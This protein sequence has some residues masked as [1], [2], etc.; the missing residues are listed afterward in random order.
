MAQSFNIAQDSDEEYEPNHPMQPGDAW[1][2]MSMAAES[3]LPAGTIKMTPKIPPTF[4]GQSSW[5]EFEDLIDD[6]LGITTLTPE[7]HGPS[8]K[9]ALTGSAEFYRSMLD[10]QRL[11]DPD[12]GVAHFKDVLRPYFIKGVNH[13]FLWRFLQLFRCWRGNSDMVHWIGRYEISSR[14]VMQAWMDLQEI[15]IPAADEPA[16]VA[17]LTQQQYENLQNLPTQADRYNA[18]VAYREQMITAL[19]DQHR[20]L[21]PLSDNLMSLLFLVQADLNEQQRERFVSSMSLRQ[22]GMPQYTYAN[23]KARASDTA[24]KV[25]SSS[26]TRAIMNQNKDIGYLMRTLENRDLSRCTARRTSGSSKQKVV[27]RDARSLVADSGAT[28]KARA[29][30][31]AK[32]DQASVA[33]QKATKV[34]PTSQK[35]HRTMTQSSMEKAKER[36]ARKEKEKARMPSSKVK[37][38]TKVNRISNNKQM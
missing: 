11:R 32:Q 13:V 14:R 10:N 1:L 5:F 7:K 23:V 34:T 36:K 2:G 33:G 28:Q 31:K 26:S 6:W 19:K 9:N 30:A 27:T 38:R 8:L 17:L 29:K 22:L 16:F 35:K 18:A 20:Q 25:P 3:S 15:N 12:G 37:E 4:D 21:F 24:E